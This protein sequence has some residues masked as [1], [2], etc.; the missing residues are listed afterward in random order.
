MIN[1]GLFED[2][3]SDPLPKVETKQSPNYS[4]DLQ[5]LPQKIQTTTFAKLKYI[6]WIESNILG[7]WTQKNLEPLLSLMPEVEGEKKPSWRT[8]ARWY[9]AY[10][11]ADKSILALIPNHQKKGNRD[12]HT[13]TDKYFEKSLARYLV[14]EKPSVASAY[15][16]YADL[17]I[18]ENDSVIG[19]TL[20]PLTYK[21]F[22]N[23]IDNLPQYDIMI[24]R[25]GKRLAD[26]AF[27]K[28]EGHKRPT[29]V[30]EKVE[31]D[32]TPLDLILLDDELHIPLG[33]PTLT[34]L[35]DVYS[36]CIVGYYFSFSEP[37]YDA[38]RRAMLNAMKPKYEVA[39]L[40]PDTI[41]EWQ[42]AGKIETLVVDNGAE[43]WSNSLELACEE[44]GIN[45]QYNPVAK[46]WLKPFVERMFG[47]INTELLD[48]VPGKTFSNIL[49]KHE[50]NPKKD[51]IMR[52]TTFMQ[53]F[54]K[55]V[56]DVYHKD[57]DS[58]FKYIP[59]QLWEQGFNTLP[60]T[61]LNQEDLQQLDV[62]LSI[63]KKRIL[64][65]GGIRLENL[66][67]DSNE[68]A[69]YRK[70]FSHKESL[71]V[72]IKLNSDDISYIY[73]YLD[74]LEHYIKVPCIDPSGYTQGLSLNQHKI[75]I[76][77][78]RDFVSG[79]IDNVGLAKA[80][81]FIH[82]KIQSEFEVLK[83]SPKSTKV[84]GGKALAKH[85]NVSSDNQKSITK[86]STLVIK[87]TEEKTQPTDSWDD[88]I[89]DIDGF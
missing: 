63:S 51:A 13:S 60:P 7:G 48:P 59:S 71:E 40:Y 53:L 30:L 4:K 65:K 23:R 52:F 11:N 74:K 47:T 46:P 87:E 45:T 88:F 73:V 78:H 44:I 12:R 27:N 24:A 62:V 1:N 38:V 22:K 15:K 41:N 32:H 68:L 67:Y 50:Y 64:R 76:R 72:L 34:M 61:V 69:N 84:K 89:S 36:H 77:I 83:H 20:K 66:S 37:S 16:Y 3:F 82:N 5:T 55:W 56:V 54:H 42:C 25:Y 75:N 8:I 17:I 26:I 81:M 14:K 35:V 9:S 21:A 29:R 18:I 43:F 10:V 86:S 33:R 49:Q 6:Q 39:K 70:Q 31:I 57:S 2:E 79:A 85:Q 19:S 80:R 28:V 58:R